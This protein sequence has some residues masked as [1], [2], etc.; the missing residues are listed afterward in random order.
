MNTA[1]KWLQTCCLD[2]QGLNVKKNKKQKHNRN[3]KT[4]KL[5]N[6]KSIHLKLFGSSPVPFIVITK[7]ATELQSS[8]DSST[9]NIMDRYSNFMLWCPER[10]QQI[11]ESL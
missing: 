3:T 1:S 7:Y 5:E 4:I 10:Q 2:R 8:D 6:E 11:K 9:S